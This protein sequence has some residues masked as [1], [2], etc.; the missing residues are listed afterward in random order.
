M[1]VKE[2]TMAVG[3]PMPFD[4]PYSPATERANFDRFFVERGIP[5]KG[6]DEIDLASWNIANLGLQPRRS[7][8]LQLIAH[9][10]SHFDIIAVQ[11]VNVNLGHF[12]EVMAILGPQG[13][14]MMLTDKAGSSER[15]AVVYRADRLQPRQLFGELDYN[16]NGTIKDGKYVVAP[17]KQ[18][19]TLNGV[20]RDMLFYNFN[21]NP[22]LSTWKVTG[23][24]TSF[25]LANVHIYFGDDSETSAQYSNRVA[26][27][28]YLANW[29]REQQKLAG[30]DDLYENN[31]L[32]IGDMNVPKMKSDDPVYRALKRR[33]MKPSQYS[34]EAGTTLQEFKTFDQIVFTNEV[35]TG[36]PINGRPAVVVDFD[37]FMFRQLWQEKETGLRTMVDFKAWTKFAVSDHRPLFVRLKV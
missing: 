34:T 12:N 14:D 7:Q 24:D 10:L 29:A 15:L 36:V 6:A 11:E 25:M 8:E 20:K 19:F 27:V 17:R 13:F 16:P 18:T 31:I 4:L 37:N 32:L 28:Y 3:F 9:I 35:L 22:H 2:E 21:R 30:T 33:G 1:S 26:E 23:T 5:P